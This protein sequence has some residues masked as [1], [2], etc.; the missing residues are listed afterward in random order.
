MRK[1]N[2][3]FFHRPSRTWPAPGTSQATKKAAPRMR[4]PFFAR[5]ATSRK[6]APPTMRSILVSKRV[7]MLHAEFRAQVGR[8]HDRVCHELGRRAVGQDLTVLDYIRA[9]ADVKSF[10]HVV[11]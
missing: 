4:S 1:K 5:R 9:I 3:P 7:F 10:P 2:S 11:V 8:A 6:M